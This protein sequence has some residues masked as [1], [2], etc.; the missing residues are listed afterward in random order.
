MI[1]I[2]LLT[3]AGVGILTGLLGG[4]SGPLLIPILMFF[5]RTRHIPDDILMHTAVGTTLAIAL[6]AMIASIHVHYKR[7]P[8]IKSLALKFIPGGIIGS[9]LGVILA[10]HLSTLVFKFLFGVI[11]ITIALSILFGEKLAKNQQ[12]LP[13]TKILFLM[14]IPMGL[15]ATCFG[16]GM[17]PLCVPLLQRYGKTT[18]YSIAAATLIG[19]ILVVFAVAG[20]AI[21][22]AS[23]SHLPKYSL[24]Y[25]YLPL[26]FWMGV[27]TILG[28]RLGSKLAHF[29]PAKTI[30]IVFV[31]FLLAVGIKVM[32]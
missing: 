14:S 15:I 19:G 17:G 23:N 16:I 4:G 3:G 24:G 30:K 5:L 2:Y 7:M 25:I 31:L 6:L 9:L 1:L 10:D 12:S 27:P 28:A 32:F 20:F 29:F 13:K 21:S 26:V 18:A 11:V 8:D 22:G